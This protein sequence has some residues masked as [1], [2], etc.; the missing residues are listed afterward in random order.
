MH[1]SPN[2]EDGDES[3]VPTAA[4]LEVLRGPCQ[5]PPLLLLHGLGRR[6][7]D[8]LP[9]IQDVEPRVEWYALDMRGHGGSSRLPNHYHVIDYLHDVLTFVATNFR[10]PIVIYGHSLGALLAGATAA[11]LPEFVRGIILEDP[12]GPSFLDRIHETSYHALFTAMR[13]LAGKSRTPAEIARQLSEVE[14]PTSSGRTVRFGDIR[15]EDSIRFSAECLVDVDGEVYTPILEHQ[16]FKDFDWAEVWRDVTCPAL[17]LQ[18]DTSFG[19]ML[20]DEDAAQMQ[21]LCPKLRTEKFSGIGHL[22][23]WTVMPRTQ[24]LVHEFLDQLPPPAPIPEAEPSP[25]PT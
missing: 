22:I 2:I 3:A 6:G 21:S 10:E 17:L 12:P 15:D 14:L 19:G 11:A 7:D 25:Q 1:E 5:G 16:W 9:F 24:T 18:G 13:S 23:H 4:L 8:F 20:P